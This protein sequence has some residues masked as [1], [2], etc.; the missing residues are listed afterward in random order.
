MAGL[1]LAA[2]AV[3][4]GLITVGCTHAVSGR[5]TVNDT[6][7]AAHRSSVASSSSA[8]SSSRAAA[9]LGMVCAPLVAGA[10]E[11]DFKI[12]TFERRLDEQADREAVEAAARNAGAALSD[13]GNSV[14]G[15]LRVNDVAAEKNSVFVEYIAATKDFA[16]E[17]NSLVIRSV[18]VDIFVEA[19]ERYDEAS[20]AAIKACV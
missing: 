7:L 16:D 3:G 1:I 4:G 15:A 2:M 6:D 11:I 18:D 12:D 13:T 10:M 17:M 19:W 8:A 5:A 9:A 20:D 14:E